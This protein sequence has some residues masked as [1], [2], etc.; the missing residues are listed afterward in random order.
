MDVQQVIT[1][2]SV[3]SDGHAHKVPVWR[4][5]RAGGGDGCEDIRCD[6][7]ARPSA[8]RVM[9]GPCSFRVHHFFPIVSVAEMEA[10]YGTSGARGW[11]PYESGLEGRRDEW[12]HRRASIDAG[13]FREHAP[14][15]WP[16]S[17]PITSWA[18]RHARAPALHTRG[19]DAHATAFVRSCP[20]WCGPSRPR[21]GIADHHAMWF[22]K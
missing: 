19:S 10:A 4:V 12:C 15:S 22:T 14:M 16:R 6:R 8:V 20:P 11:K 9:G 13:S 3:A 2:Y 21:A 18:S 5:E 1:S 7:C 17:R